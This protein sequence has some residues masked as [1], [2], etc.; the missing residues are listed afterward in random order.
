MLTT[1]FKRKTM[2]DFYSTTLSSRSI[3]VTSVE[4]RKVVVDISMYG[5]YYQ[6]FEVERQKNR[7]KFGE[8]ISCAK[9]NEVVYSKKEKV[10]FMVYLEGFE[11]NPFESRD[12]LCERALVLAQDEEEVIEIDLIIT[13]CLDLNELVM[14]HEELASLIL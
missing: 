14:M 6:E 1:N 2:E 12:T 11:D 13:G 10:G 9:K 3:I 8:G 5:H 4:W 7:E